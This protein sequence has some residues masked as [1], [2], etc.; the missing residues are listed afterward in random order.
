MRNFKFYLVS[1][2]LFSCA[3]TYKVPP[4][5]PLELVIPVEKKIVFS[6]ILNLLSNDNYSI[7]VVDHQSGIITTDFRTLR[8]EEKVDNFFINDITVQGRLSFN[9]FQIDENH[10]KINLVPT[11]KYI[12]PVSNQE[13]I[14][15]VGSA[16]PL[17]KKWLSKLK[18]I[19]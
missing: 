6:K 15:P 12:S 18:G 3:S 7:A 10:T 8:Q 2:L 5:K 14:R 1:M 11:I 4:T 13:N 17:Y 19:N 9:I 16:H